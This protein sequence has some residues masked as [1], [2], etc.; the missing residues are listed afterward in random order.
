MLKLI[1]VKNST[2]QFGKHMGF[3]TLCSMNTFTIFLRIRYYFP[4]GESVL[5]G[6]CKFL[7]NDLCVGVVTI[8]YGTPSEVTTRFFS[9][10]V[11]DDL[12]L[13]SATTFIIEF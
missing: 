5:T 4:G 7:L 1:N 3:D 12:A 6:V 10:C 13:S 2:N 11:S 8:N 9:P